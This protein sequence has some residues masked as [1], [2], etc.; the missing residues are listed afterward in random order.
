MFVFDLNELAEFKENAPG[1][2]VLAQSGHARQVLFS[3]KAGQGLREHTTSSQIAVQVISGEIQFGARGEERQ[4][5][6]GKLLLLE[7]NVP[8][9]LLAVTDSVMLLS[10]TPNPSQ[11]SLHKELFAEIKPMAEWQ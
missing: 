9:N 11:H 10:L 7:E 3:L 6:A 5:N 2:Q 8:H 1:V 4:L